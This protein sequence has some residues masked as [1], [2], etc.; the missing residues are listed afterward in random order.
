MDYLLPTHGAEFVRAG[1]IFDQFKGS[2]QDHQKQ[3][4]DQRTRGLRR[5]RH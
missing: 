2:I 1:V 3:V 5:R 4:R